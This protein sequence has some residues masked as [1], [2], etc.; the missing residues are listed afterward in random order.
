MEKL[1]EA[2]LAWGTASVARAGEVE[3]GDHHLV[4]PFPGGALVAAIDG[5]G[6]GAGAASAARK[7]AATMAEHASESVISLVRHCHARLVGTR[8]VVMSLAS[9]NVA[10]ETMTWLSVGN[11]EGFLLRA[12]V[13]AAPE[14]EALVMRGGVVGDRLPELRASVVPVSRGDTL[15]FATDGVQGG[16]AAEINAVE[17]P[18]KVADRILALHKRGTDDALIVVAR[19]LG[20]ET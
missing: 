19:Y 17:S 1:N 11:V 9:F 16:F 5:L 13:G 3:C 4:E 6:H 8:G 10:D 7:A 14:R 18:Q 12:E 2:V 20:T 15:I